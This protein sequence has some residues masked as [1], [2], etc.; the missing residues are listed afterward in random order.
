M[1]LAGFTLSHRT[2]VV[3]LVLLLTAWG[4]LT[5][6]NIPR[7]EDPEY[8]VRT[9]Q[10]LTQWPGTPVDR[11]EDLITYPIE[12]EVATM[13][14]LRWV[15]SETTLGR[16]AVYVELDRDYPGDGVMQKWDEVR[17]RARRVA[18]PEPGIVPVVIDD[19][20]DTNIMVMALYQ[21]PLPGDDEIQE[22]N[23]YTARQ[24][25]IFSRRLYDELKLV[26][27]V[28]KV[29]RNGVRQEAVYIETDLGTWS[30]LSMSSAELAELVSRRNVVAPGGIIDTDTGRFAVKPSG[31]LAA[32]QELDALVVGFVEEGDS[33]AP[34]YLED[35]GLDVARDYEDPPSVITRYADPD[36][37]QPC[38][39]VAFTMKSGANIVDVCDAAKATIRR[40]TVEQKVLPSD[41]AVSLVSD[42]SENV[43]AKISDFV[44]NV[45]GAIAIVIAVVYLMVGL[46]TASV[47]AANIPVVIIGSLALLPLFDVDLEQISIAA[48]IIAL[49]L[50]VDNAV[51]VSNE[52]MRLQDEGLDPDEAA[53]QGSNMLAGAIIYGTLTT[54]AAFFPMIFALKGSSSEYVRSLP[55]TISIT[56]A[57]SYILA[58]T[59][60][61][62][63]ASVF[64]RPAAPGVPHSP[65]LRWMQ[66]LRGSK[67]APGGA[68]E[69]QRPEQTGP[70]Q[71]GDAEQQGGLASLYPRLVAAALHAKWLVVGGSF[72]LLALAMMLPV[73]SQYFPQ[74]LRDQFAIEV[75]LPEGASIR[76]TDAAARK[77]EDMVRKLSPF[78]TEEGEQVERLRA[79]ASTVG[80]GMSRWYMG[81]NP[82]SQKSYYAEIVVRVTE[83]HL[84]QQLVDEIRV[85]A[86]EGDASR[87]IDPVVGARVIPRQ[88]SMGPP[89]DAPVAVRLFGPRLGVGFA[90]ETLMRE[91]AQKLK[92]ILRARPETWDVFDTWGS[93][94][95][96]LDIQV[97]EDRANLSGVTNEGLADT[98]NAYFSGRYLTTYREKDH[99]VP[100]YLRLRADER[101]DVAGLD[102]AYVEGL[103]GKVP[104]DSVATVEPVLAPARIDR[105]F[106][107]R[108]IEVR[109]RNEEGYLANDIV[110]ALFASPE[111]EQWEAELPP[112][113]WW[114]VGGEMFESQSSAPDM[115][116]SFMISLLLIPLLLIIQYNGLFKPFIIVMTLPLALIGGFPGLWITGN[117]FGFMPQLG[118]LSLFGVVVNAA[119]IFIEFADRIIKEK[120]L[121]SDGSGPI[122]G[123]TV[124]EFRGC[125][126]EA[127]KLRLSPIAMTTLTT[128]GG[129]L[130]LALGGGPLWEGMSWLMIYGL[131][132]ATL[133]TLV[134]VPCL[135]AIFVETFKVA[136][137]RLEKKKKKD[138]GDAA[139]QSAPAPVAG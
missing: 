122:L 75:W 61:T 69:Q 84:T 110:K 132:V 134:V 64:I 39:T 12:D 13:D 66:K 83:G 1:N 32:E 56:L 51:Q 77:V 133:L 87:D 60:C 23:R 127:G 81:R 101:V 67:P 53:E 65:V 50:L 9:C 63:L 128:I 109:A 26:D 131:T 115:K 82:E 120:A 18:M 62:H 137:V 105:R 96:Q 52:C 111:F 104:L 49:G 92:D 14:G 98:L 85:I 124:Q 6:L 107:Q 113:F 135:Y 17:A 2:I 20:G 15:R 55:I 45:L 27:G 93:K 59:F 119:I 100:V 54:I 8:T 72:G 88:L 102:A 34:V 94:G 19:F 44:A 29:V 22:R 5:F 4:T 70:E 40:L 31:N 37:W 129:L 47:M 48:M 126:I 116:L 73:G 58:M 74:D 3:S 114:Q 35:M 139:P 91:H 97:D 10:I 136:P 130:P 125:L 7:R 95:Y 30:R 46:R 79:M 28:S 117:A 71:G 43:N 121:A 33:R 68:P 16:S 76:E 78:T 112:G 106:L 42:Q 99:L 57:L 80:A 123:L 138:E 41:I 118:L 24:L 90:D 89:V 11:V 103:N 108:V 36:S 38:N 21:T 25:D 86:R